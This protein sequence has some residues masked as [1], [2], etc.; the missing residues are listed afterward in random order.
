MPAEPEPLRRFI[1]AKRSQPTWLISMAITP[2][3]QR[4]RASIESKRPK[5][6]AFRLMGLVFTTCMATSGNGVPIIGMTIIKGH[7]MMA[8]LGSQMIKTLE[9]CCGAVRGTT[10]PGV[11]ALL[12]ATTM[13]R[14]GATTTSVFGLSVVRP[15]LLS[16]LLSFPF[17]L[18]TS[19]LFSPSERSERSKIFLCDTGCAPMSCGFSHAASRS[20]RSGYSVHSDYSV[21]DP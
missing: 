10:F 12:F 21:T 18:Y 1:L 8:V 15:G 19:S 3:A 11:V 16:P 20:I 13:L 9:C 17:A 2:M 7:R 4:P 5:W 6:A 14:A